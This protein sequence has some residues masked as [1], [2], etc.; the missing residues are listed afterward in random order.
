MQSSMAFVKGLEEVYLLPSDPSAT[1]QLASFFTP[2]SL[3]NTDSGTPPHSLQLMMPCVY[4]TVTGVA[5]FPSLLTWR[6]GPVFPRHSRNAI[7]ETEGRRF[8]PSMVNASGLSTKPGMLKLY[9]SR[10]LSSSRV[11]NLLTTHT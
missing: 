1:S 11:S 8:R 5:F 9:F 10:S 6:R 7:L 2:T 3:S 4:W